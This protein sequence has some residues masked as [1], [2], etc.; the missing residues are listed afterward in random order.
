MNRFSTGGCPIVRIGNR[1]FMYVEQTNKI[2]GYDSSLTEIGFEKCDGIFERNVEQK[3]IDSAYNVI[4]TLGIFHDFK[5]RVIEYDLNA[6]KILVAFNT[7]D[8]RAAGIPPKCDQFDK[9]N[10][11]YEAYVP[12][13][14]INEIYEIRKPA[15]DF[16]FKS[17]E[18]VYHKKNGKWLPYHEL[19]APLKDDEW[20]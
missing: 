12:E 6:Q 16:P 4:N 17:P 20:L 1:M 9:N 3:E 10:I 7:T 14:D 19:G 13:E 11:Y 2:F 8:G 15:K 18:I 5:V